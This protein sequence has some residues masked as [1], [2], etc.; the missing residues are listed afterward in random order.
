MYTSSKEAW[1]AWIIYMYRYVCF[2]L[3]FSPD[4]FRVISDEAETTRERFSG[5]PHYRPPSP[6]RFEKGISLPNIYNRSTQVLPKAVPD[7]RANNPHPRS[8]GF[9]RHDVRL[10]NEPICS[11]YTSVTHD[12]QNQW[13]P[14]RT[15][16]EPLQVP[17][18]TKDTVYRSDY[19][20][21]HNEPL[22][23]TTRHE[24]NSCR[25][26]ALGPGIITHNNLQ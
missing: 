18:K 14:S 10:L 15:S 26:A 11:V 2:I 16:D 19:M 5:N 9:L 20:R 22:H 8:C 12:E 24:S 7:F 17:G 21:E 25:D 1:S 3:T 23:R 13:W 4:S 6:E